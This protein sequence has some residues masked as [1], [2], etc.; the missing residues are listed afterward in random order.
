M[1]SS[2]IWES[3]KNTYFEE[4][5]RTTGSPTATKSSHIILEILVVN[6]LLFIESFVTYCYIY[7]IYIV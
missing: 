6:I 3:F 5:L 1:F 2:E 4:H 7:I